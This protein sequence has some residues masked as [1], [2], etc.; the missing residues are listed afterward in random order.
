MR[1]F[2]WAVRDSG[3]DEASDVFRYL[4]RFVCHFIA[5]YEVTAR[6]FTL[7][8]SRWSADKAN[9]DSY[10]GHQGRLMGDVVDVPLRVAA[11]SLPSAERNLDAWLYDNATILRF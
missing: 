1:L 11:T 8:E 5:I 7:L 4:Q 3:Y 2:F 9:T 10:L 6:P